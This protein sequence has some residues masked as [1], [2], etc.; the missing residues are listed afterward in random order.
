MKKILLVF[1]IM[2]L[3]ILNTQAFIPTTIS[4][5]QQDPQDETVADSVSI[6]DAAPI[7]YDAEEGTEEDIPLKEKNPLNWALY[8]GGAALIIII[9]TVLIRRNK[10]DGDR[11]E[12]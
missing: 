4:L 6:D 9:A 8:L 1:S 2:G 12:E 7:F 11:S 10:K 3:L 5:A